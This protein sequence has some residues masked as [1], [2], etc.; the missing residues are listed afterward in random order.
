MRAPIAALAA[1]LLV[2]ASAP[3]VHAG[4]DPVV[5]AYDHR[6]DVQIF[7]NAGPGERQRR[8]I[9]LYRL[10]VTQ[11]PDK[12]RFTVRL[13]KVLPES[14]KYD[15]MVH[16]TLE[17]APANGDVSAGLLPPENPDIWWTS[18]SFSPQHPSDGRAVLIY[19]A[20]VIYKRCN[21][22]VTGANAAKRKA[23][24]DVPNKCVPESPAKIKLNS[25]LG[26]SRWDPPVY[27]KDYMWVKGA[28][29]L[30]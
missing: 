5:D 18:Y 21:P 28:H 9:D 4:V 2:G 11:F 16:I 29:N 10:T 23:Y 6:Q 7:H 1:L 30:R 19:D 17:P 20:D 8:S 27:S 3:A 12:V 15:Q 26:A 14:Y 25:Y 13:K 24:I 22:A